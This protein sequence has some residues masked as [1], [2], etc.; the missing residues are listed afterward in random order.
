MLAVGKIKMLRASVSAGGAEALPAYNGGR[1]MSTTSLAS[2]HLKRVSNNKYGSGRM[3]SQKS[4]ASNGSEGSNGMKK[5]RKKSRKSVNAV[6]PAM[7]R[8]RSQGVS[9]VLNCRGDSFFLF[10]LFSYSIFFSFEIY[11]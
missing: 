11:N 3:N 2:Q 5:K 7:G 9:K 6:G 4:K 1:R 10:S 8:R